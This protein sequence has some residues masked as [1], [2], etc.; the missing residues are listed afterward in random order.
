MLHISKAGPP[1]AGSAAGW[2]CV[3]THVSPA[4]LKVSYSF[5]SYL[6]GAHILLSSKTKALLFL[7]NDS[8]NFSSSGIFHLL[9]GCTQ[10]VRGGRSLIGL[11]TCSPGFHFLFHKDAG[12]PR[13]DLSLLK[14]SHFWATGRNPPFPG[15]APPFGFWNS[16]SLQVWDLKLEACFLGLQK[17]FSP[18]SYPNQ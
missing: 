2:L 1:A 13:S 15:R 4:A 5:H 8:H 10:A 7:I 14:R 18:S 6:N 3:I 11:L 16:V 12:F 9:A 17:L